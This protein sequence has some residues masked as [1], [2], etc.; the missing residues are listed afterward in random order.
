MTCIVN[1]I[2]VLDAM[3]KTDD[4]DEIL[5]WV[6][7]DRHIRLLIYSD[8]DEPVFKRKDGMCLD[9]QFFNRVTHWAYL[10]YPKNKP[11]APVQPPAHEKPE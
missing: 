9:K 2:S 8:V 7:I 6:F 1:W 5:I 11:N 10:S 3:P 4:L